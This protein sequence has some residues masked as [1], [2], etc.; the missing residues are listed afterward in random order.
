MTNVQ[1]SLLTLRPENVHLPCEYVP[2]TKSSWFSSGVLL[3]SV[4]RPK[5]IGEKD[6][7]VL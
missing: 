7:V 2:E 6:R 5:A 4:G 1:D 3:I